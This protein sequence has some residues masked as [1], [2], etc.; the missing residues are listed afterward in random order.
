VG[1]QLSRLDGLAEQDRHFVDAPAKLCFQGGTE[2]CP[3]S[4]DH[5]LGCPPLFAFSGL[6]LNLHSGQVRV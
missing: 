6:D 4:A 3:D 1:D 5:F 2:F